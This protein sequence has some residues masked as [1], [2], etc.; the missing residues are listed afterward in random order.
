[1]ITCLKIDIMPVVSADPGRVINDVLESQNHH[2]QY[3]LHCTFLLCIL[4]FDFVNPDIVL[5]IQ[6]DRR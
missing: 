3:F 4:L 1:M 5:E 2:R 6:K